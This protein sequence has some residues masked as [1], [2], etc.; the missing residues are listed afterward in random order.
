MED[1]GYL[2]KVCL[3]RSILVTNFHLLHGHKTF[4]GE[5]IYGSACFSGISTFSQKKEAPDRLLSVSV[6]SQMSLAQ[7]NS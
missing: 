3:C 5:R 1:K 7:N 4:L 2:S 6:E